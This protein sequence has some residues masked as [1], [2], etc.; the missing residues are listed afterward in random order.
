MRAL[1]R[2]P[3]HALVGLLVV[4]LSLLVPAN[5]GADYSWGWNGNG[6]ISAGDPINLIFDIGGTWPRTYDRVLAYTGWYDRGGSTQ[7]FPDHSASAWDSQDA[8]AGSDVETA[9]R[10]HIRYDEGNDYGGSGW[11]WWTMAP[12]HYEEVRWCGWDQ[13]WRHVV[14]TFDGAR[15]SVH[16]AFVNN[17]YT[18]GWVN[19]GLTASRGQCDGS[20]VSS[21]GQYVW[22]DIP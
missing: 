10:Y 8:Q 2:K 13:G 20:S 21:D 1:Q 18:I 5:A 4:G 12:A 15:N 16:N 3:R 22:I 11:G 17:G 7:S 14:T 6:Y 19:R 9:N